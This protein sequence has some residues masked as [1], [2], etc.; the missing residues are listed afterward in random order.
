MANVIV[1]EA[2]HNTHRQKLSRYEDFE[3]RERELRG[4]KPWIGFKRTHNEIVKL[5][6]L[7]SEVIQGLEIIFVTNKNGIIEII[8]L[9]YI[10]KNPEPNVEAIINSDKNPC[11]KDERFVINL[12]EVEDYL[13]HLDRAIDG[14]DTLEF[15]LGYDEIINRNKVIMQIIDKDGKIVTCGEGNTPIELP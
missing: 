10:S 5:L 13:H 2:G 8:L 11:F 4:K 14:A 12:H 6:S 3:E 7:S 15:Y 9:P 1:Y